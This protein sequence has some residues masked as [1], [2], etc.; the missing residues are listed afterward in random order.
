MLKLVSFLALV[1]IACAYYEE[2]EDILVPVEALPQGT[3]V[4]VRRQ[5]FGSFG[6]FGSGFNF[7]NLGYPSRSYGGIDL[8]S[9]N[10]PAPFTPTHTFHQPSSSFNFGSAANGPFAGKY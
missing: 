3:L 2:P 1:A 9:L 6:S 4:R 7:G 8:S 5:A 10:R